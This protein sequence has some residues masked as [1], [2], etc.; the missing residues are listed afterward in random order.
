MARRKSKNWIQKAIEKPGALR[1]QLKRLGII[2]GDQKIPTDFLRK[3]KNAEIG[4]T[5]KYKGKRIKVT[6]K[7]KKRCVLALTL[8]RFHK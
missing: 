3:V 8:R 7:L 2:K 6:D 4:S 5:I 1:A